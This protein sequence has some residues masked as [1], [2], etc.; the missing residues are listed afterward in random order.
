[1]DG[2]IMPDRLPPTDA[3]QARMNARAE[4]LRS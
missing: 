1:M 2:A 4:A 3:L